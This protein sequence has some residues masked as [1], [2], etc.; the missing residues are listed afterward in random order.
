M[1]SVVSCWSWG[2]LRFEPKPGKGVGVQDGRAGRESTCEGLGVREVS[3]L[4][5]AASFLVCPLQLALQ[6]GGEAAQ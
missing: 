3:Q 5:M 1:S 6:S 2:L 4:E